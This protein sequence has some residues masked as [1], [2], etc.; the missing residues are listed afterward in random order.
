M[1]QNLIILIMG[2]GNDKVS[3]IIKKVLSRT[4][5]SYQ[6]VHIRT[7]KDDGKQFLLDVLDTESEEECLK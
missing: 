7:V 3:K 1:N 6:R 4:S 2:K 5:D